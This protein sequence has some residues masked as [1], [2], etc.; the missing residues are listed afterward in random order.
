MSGTGYKAPLTG[1]AGTDGANAHFERESLRL[2]TEA[3]AFYACA[4]NYFKRLT[5]FFS[6][7]EVLNEYPN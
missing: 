6:C 7:L 2:V 5:Q 4:S 3:H 1:P